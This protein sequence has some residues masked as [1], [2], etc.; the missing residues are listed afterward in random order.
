MAGRL[1][2][3]LR[4][5]A[6]YMAFYGGTIFFVLAALAS[7]PLKGRRVIAVVVDGWSRYHRACVH[8]LL[9]IRI[10]VNGTLPREGALIAMK[11]ESFFEAIDLTVLFHQPLIFAKAELLRIPLW[12]KAA[13]AYG[14]IPVERSQGAKALRTMIATARSRMG[15]GRVFVIFPEGTRIPHGTHADLQA[16]FTALYKLLGLPVVPV[17]VDSGP[18][19]HRWWKRR[20]TITISV[21]EPIPPGLPRPEIEAR[22]LEA[23]NVLNG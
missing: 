20:G 12:G 18:L 5:L 11:H 9:G 16:G 1:G 17:A 19:Y 4:S 6:F 15:E 3:M 10:R 22:V 23:I 7:I 21:G 14:L 13:G 2:E 8:G